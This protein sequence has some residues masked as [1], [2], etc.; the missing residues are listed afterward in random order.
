MDYFKMFING[1]TVDAIGG[2]KAEAI[3]PGTGKVIATFAY[4]GPEDANAAVD[5]ARK[6]FD[7]G[8]WSNMQPAERSRILIELSDLLY[9]YIPLLAKWEALDSGG[10]ITRTSFDVITVIGGLEKPCSVCGL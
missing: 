2:T 7:S 4:G 6:A 8:V 5:A 10:L 9:E 1:E 3:D